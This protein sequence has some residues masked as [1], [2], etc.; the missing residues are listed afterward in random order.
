MHQEPAT[1][2]VRKVCTEKYFVL[3]QA[4]QTSWITE[5]RPGAHNFSGVFMHLPSY[6]YIRGHACIFVYKHVCIVC[7]CHQVLQ[8]I[9]GHELIDSG[10]SALPLARFLTGHLPDDT[11]VRPSTAGLLRRRYG[12]SHQTQL[13]DGIYFDCKRRVRIEYVNNRAISRLAFEEFQR[14]ENSRLSGDTKNIVYCRPKDLP[15]RCRDVVHTIDLQGKPVAHPLRFLETTQREVYRRF[16][17]RHKKAVCYQNQIIIKDMKFDLDSASSV[18]HPRES[19]KTQI[20]DKLQCKLGEGAVKCV[21]HLHQNSKN[22][23]WW[24]CVKFSDSQL[25]D[26][27]CA[28]P[29]WLD[30]GDVAYGH[31]RAKI[32]ETAFNECRPPWVVDNKRCTCLCWRCVSASMMF[33]YAK[34]YRTFWMGTE[35]YDE[36][37]SRFQKPLCPEFAKLIDSAKAKAVYGDVQFGSTVDDLFSCIFCKVGAIEKQCLRPHTATTCLPIHT[38]IFTHIQ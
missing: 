36:V 32:C 9:I 7:A 24:C 8:K 17:Q 25:A 27:A 20:I 13:I 11:S 38:T 1:P 12:N 35:C 18:L 3:L 37:D 33:K 15:P 23:L 34:K 26:A 19:V 21:T 5:F 30:F 4:P 29:N 10:L 6:I 2:P 31:R 16:L 28:F 14:D 22:E